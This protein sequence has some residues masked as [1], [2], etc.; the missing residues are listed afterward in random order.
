MPPDATVLAE[1]KIGSA[2]IGEPL[3]LKAERGEVRSVAVLGYGLYR[4]KLMGQGQ[5]AARGQETQDLLTSFVGN[6]VQ[7]LSV[8]EDEKRV[9]IRSTFDVYSSGENVTFSATVQDQTLS[10]VNDAE[11]TIDVVG[12][13]QKRSVICSNIGNGQYTGNIGPLP[14]GDY[15]FNGVASSRGSSLGSDYGRFVVTDVS[16]EETALTMNS[17]LLRLLAERSG[18]SYAPAPDI[19]DLITKLKDDPRLQPIVRTADREHALYHTPWFVALSL[20]SFSLEWFL[21]KRKGLV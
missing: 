13:A 8:R 3:I 16:V 9:Q 18:G 1:L 15:E 7:Y 21:R 14:P 5:S 11:V 19:E 2:A 20:L 6:T 10:A 12:G 17:S 4:W